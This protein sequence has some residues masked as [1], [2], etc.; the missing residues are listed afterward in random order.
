M[1][2][3]APIAKT[4]KTKTPAKKKATVKAAKVK[5]VEKKETKKIAAVAKR[6][7]VKTK[8]TPVLVKAKSKPKKV[9][10]EIAKPIAI[11]RIVTH[12]K[13]RHFIPAHTQQSAE[14]VH[15]SN[16]EENVFHNREEVALKQE[17]QKVRDGAISKTNVK[18]IFNSQGRR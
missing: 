18:R 4:G 7:A 14:N 2:K 10:E 9:A 15:D 5:T 16:A 8:K 11:T 12:G 3:K 17:E 1:Q 13:D 6:P